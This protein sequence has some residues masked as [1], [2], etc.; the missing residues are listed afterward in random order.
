MTKIKDAVDKAYII[1]HSSSTEELSKSLTK[2]NLD[3][4]ELR[5]K[6]KKSWN[7]YSNIYKCLLNHERAWKKAL[8]NE[9]TLI[10]EEDFVPVSNFGDFSLPFDPKKDFGICWIYYCGPRIYSASDTGYIEGGATS[11]VAYIINKKSAALLIEFAK[12][13]KKT[14]KGKYYPFDSDIDGYF[15]KKGLKNYIAFRNYGEHGGLPNPEHRQNK[16][17]NQGIHRADVLAGKLDF[18]PLY[19]KHN[20]IIYIVVRIKARI[21]GLVRLFSGRYLRPKIFCSSSFPLRL[22]KCAIKRHL[23]WNL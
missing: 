4:E 6:P 8:N 5:Q 13:M 1:C 20:I 15:I 7:K 14:M 11:L 22:L 18:M 19:S 2:N 23:T 17:G 10:V 16:T 3:V 21:K 9:F 12:K